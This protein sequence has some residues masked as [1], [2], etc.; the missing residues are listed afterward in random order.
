M[1]GAAVPII[2]M[3]VSTGLQLAAQQQA[4]SERKRSIANMMAVRSDATNKVSQDIEQE[5]ANYDPLVRRQNQEQIRSD[6]EAR[7][8]ND[9]QAALQAPTKSV[10]VGRVDPQLQSRDAANRAKEAER[11]IQNIRLFS[12]VQAPSTQRFLE[13]LN[14]ADAASRRSTINS[15]A[16]AALQRG[17]AA[18]NSIQPNAALTTAGGLIGGAGQAYGQYQSGQALLDAFKTPAYNPYAIAG[19][20]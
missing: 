17:G 5:A 9:L 11:Q 16:R 7:M 14:A 6:D 1:A 8:V 20:T 10:P 2:S 3:V 12:K 4:N 19:H 13:S 18:Y 15:G